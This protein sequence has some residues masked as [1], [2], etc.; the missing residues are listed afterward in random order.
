MDRLRT[1]TNQPTPDRDPDLESKFQLHPHTW[2]RMPILR[3]R[4]CHFEMPSL[5][6][7]STLIIL[8]AGIY[9]F[10]PIKLV[11]CGSHLAYNTALKGSISLKAQ[12][13]VVLSSGIFVD[14]N[15]ARW[16]WVSS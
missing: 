9:S 7:S 5:R 15:H 8:A 4:A 12:G 10:S 13:R 11:K 1:S 3:R 14:E 16:R 2:C 6:G